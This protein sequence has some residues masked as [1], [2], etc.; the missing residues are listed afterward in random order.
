[1]NI[2]PLLDKL[3]KPHFLGLLLAASALLVAAIWALG[4]RPA[5]A[6]NVELRD[7]LASF[8]NFDPSTSA[9]AINPAPLLDR[10]ATITEILYGAEG[11][12]SPEELEADVIGRLQT[13]S[14]RHD[15]ELQSIQPRQGDEVDGF[16]ETNFSVSVVGRYP[17]LYQWL[18]G[19]D[20]EL[21]FIVIKDFRMQ[22]LAATDAS[23]IVVDVT[24]ATYRSL[25]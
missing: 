23:N 20:R 4:A 19:L 5:L 13:L 21:G 8:A 14:W 11:A 22:P 6:R 1:M 3:E 18:T 2:L 9:A 17:D 15:I 25:P 12:L 7:E 24:L 16:Q 10:L